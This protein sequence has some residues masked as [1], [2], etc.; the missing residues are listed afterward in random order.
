MLRLPVRLLELY[1][2]ES[3]PETKTL[4]YSQSASGDMPMSA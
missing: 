3:V 4:I 1:V 2:S